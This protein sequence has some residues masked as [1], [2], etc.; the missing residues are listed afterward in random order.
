VTPKKAVAPIRAFVIFMM[1]IEVRLG[2]EG[3]R[4]GVDWMPASVKC[5]GISFVRR[6]TVLIPYTPSL[7]QKEPQF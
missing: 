1:M 2:N 6:L 3:T 5:N 4:D 7:L